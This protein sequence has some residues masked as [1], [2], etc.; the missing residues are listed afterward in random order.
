[1]PARRRWRRPT[2]AATPPPTP[3]PPA[4]RL[5]LRTEVLAG[6]WEALITGQADLAIG[7]VAGRELPP[8]VTMKDLGPMEFVFAVAPHHPLAADERADRRQRADPPSRGRG[9]RFGAADG[10]DHPQ[11]A[12]RPGRAHRQRHEPPRSMPCCAASAAASCPSRWP[13]TTSPPAAWWSSRC[14]APGSRAASATPGARRWRPAAA[15]PGS[16]RSGLALRWW[17]EQL[18]SET[19]RKALL[20]RHGGR[21][22]D[23]IR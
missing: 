7:G 18:E 15:R 9:R 22:G 8:G 10:A 1:M 2:R 21:V 20:E 4:T 17:L 12:R 14:S 11:P 3:T 13:A 5:R 16:R 6:T 23:R 19:T